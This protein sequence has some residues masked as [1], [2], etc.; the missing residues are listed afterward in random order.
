MWFVMCMCVFSLDGLRGKQ[1]LFL[2]PALGR[3]AGQS[4]TVAEAQLGDGTKLSSE[5]ST[6]DETQDILKSVQSMMSTIVQKVNDIKN[7]NQ[8]LRGVVDKS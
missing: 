1:A 4:M 5:G 3:H 2:E 6:G 7:K 8:E